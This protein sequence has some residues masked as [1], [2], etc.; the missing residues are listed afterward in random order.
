[1]ETNYFSAELVN[2]YSKQSKNGVKLFHSVYAVDT[3]RTEEFKALVKSAK[4]VITKEEVDPE[5]QQ[6][7][8]R[9][10]T[11]YTTRNSAGHVDDRFVDIFI[12][13]GGNISVEQA[14]VNRQKR[15]RENAL[16][17]EMLRDMGIDLNAVAMRM[18][19]IDTPQQA[20]AQ[21]PTSLAQTKAP[22]PKRVVVE[23]EVTSETD[24]M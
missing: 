23:E 2:F 19:G 1:M 7:T 6:A 22:A 10:L 5:S 20:T 13:K 14:R 8:G 12:N 16:K 9:L 18:M 3:E 11:W 24:I 17:A 15:E 21:Q 4:Y